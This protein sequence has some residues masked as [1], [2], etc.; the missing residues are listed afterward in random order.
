MTINECDL[1]KK[2]RVK[3]I[4]TDDAKLKLRLYEIGFFDSSE[5]M[6]LNKSFAGKTFLISVLDSCF[7]IKAGMAAAIEVECD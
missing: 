6:L 1:N 5:I 7:A 3:S 4:I 2:Y